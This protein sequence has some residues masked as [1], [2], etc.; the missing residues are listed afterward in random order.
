MQNLPGVYAK[1]Q[2]AAYVQE[3]QAVH[4]SRTKAG[5]TDRAGKLPDCKRDSLHVHSRAACVKDVVPAGQGDSGSYRG[6]D[7]QGDC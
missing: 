4:Q 3:Q 1:E 2:D 6:G 7:C 5:E